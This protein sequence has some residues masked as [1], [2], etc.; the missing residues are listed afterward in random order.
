MKPTE[1][2]ARGSAIPDVGMSEEVD[3]AAFSL[4]VNAVSDPITTP[5]G[6]AIVRVTERQDVTDAQIA[7]GRDD[8]GEEMN[9]QRRDRFFSAYMQKAKSNLKIT[10]NQDMLAQVLGPASKPGLPPVR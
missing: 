1:L 3:Q 7:S 10:I 4:P 2:L 9:Q 6:T 8:L 5:S